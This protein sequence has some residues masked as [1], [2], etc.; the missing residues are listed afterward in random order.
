MPLAQSMEL[1]PPTATIRSMRPARANS[2]AG[3]D[4]ARGRVL[5]DG[6]EDDDFQTGL[7]Q[8]RRR[9]LRVAGRPQAGVGDEQRPRPAQLARQFAEAVQDADAEDDAWSGW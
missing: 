9:A 7:A 1:P 5:L 8:R 2:S 6:V 3:G 4:V